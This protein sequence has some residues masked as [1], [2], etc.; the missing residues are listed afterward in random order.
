MASPLNENEVNPFLETNYDVHLPALNWEKQLKVH[1]LEKAPKK[2]WCSVF[3]FGIEGRQE[4]TR[5]HLRSI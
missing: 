4:Q 3:S 5:S 1:C 2:K